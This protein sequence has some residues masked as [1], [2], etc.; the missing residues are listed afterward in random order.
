MSCNSQLTHRRRRFHFAL[1][2]IAELASC[3]V[4]NSALGQ[5]PK[6]RADSKKVQTLLK[7]R[8]TAVTKIHDGMMELHAIGVAIPIDAFMAD[9]KTLLEAQLALC[10]SNKERR[11]VYENALK[12]MAAFQKIEDA[13][14]TQRRRE[15][16]LL[17]IR[18]FRLEL[19]IGLERLKVKR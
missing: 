12:A 17:Q 11:Q 6:G 15:T 14:D 5:G 18:S 2:L 16:E 13:R 3:H 4:S 7:E 10:K 19:E 1:V 9:K 8:L